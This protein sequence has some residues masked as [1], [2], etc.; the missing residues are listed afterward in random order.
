V[1]TQGTS[2][3]FSKNGEIAASLRRFH[4]SKS[5]LLPR[6]RQI[7]GIVAGNCKK[8][9]LFG[10]PLGLSGRMRKRPKAENGRHI[11]LVARQHAVYLQVVSFAE[12]M[13]ASTA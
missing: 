5:V 3:A 1:D 2:A 10:L 4:N 6:N 12:F 9:P 11:F 8:T 13:V 7:L